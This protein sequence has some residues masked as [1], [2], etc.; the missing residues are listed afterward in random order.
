M[1]EKI[2]NIKYCYQLML[3]S[4]GMINSIRFCYEQ[5]QLLHSI[6]ST[7]FKNHKYSD[8]NIIYTYHM[9]ISDAPIY[10]GPVAL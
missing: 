7:E 5:N 1:K 6:R 9:F 3:V 10:L 2:F 8:I 4:N